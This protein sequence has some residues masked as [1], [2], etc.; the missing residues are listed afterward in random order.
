[1]ISD[2]DEEQANLEIGLAAFC[3]VRPGMP[4]GN[5][6]CTEQVTIHV[7]GLPAEHLESLAGPLLIPDLPV[8][9]W[10]PGGEIP[11]SPEC[12]GMAALADRLVLD[13]GAAGG[14]EASLRGVADLLE[15]DGVPMVGDLQWTALT[16]WR[17]LVADLF[18]LPERSG[19][20]EKIRRVEIL[21]DGAGECRALLFVGWLSVALGW[22][23]EAGVRTQEGREF[24]FDGPSGEVT[25]E[26]APNASEAT[27]RRVRL[28]SEDLT[29]QVSRHRERAYAHST[30]MRGEELLGERTVHLGSSD[31]GVL[32]GE[33]LR[34]L[35]RDEP[36]ESA[37]KR[38]VEILD[39]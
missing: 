26:L 19:E 21:H 14:C 12:D 36:Y 24:R 10:Y 1:M 7:E 5:Q 11:D 35:G 33:E 3:S 16:P 17:S 6:V 34:L 8:F 4:G 13:S 15:Q 9:L 37:L 28:Y 23:P 27:L 32:L 22:R 29:F 38:T 39:L 20:L 25:V 30:V 2:P 31:P 18:A